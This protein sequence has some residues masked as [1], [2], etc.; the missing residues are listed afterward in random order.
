MLKILIKTCNRCLVKKSIL[1]L[2]KKAKV[3]KLV[4]I[5]YLNLNQTKRN[6]KLNKKM[7]KWR[8]LNKKTW[9]LLK[10]YKKNWKNKYYLLYKSIWLKK[11]SRK[12]YKQKA[13]IAN[14]SELLQLYA[15]QKQFENCK[16]ET[17][18]FTCE[19]LWILL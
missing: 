6:L 19:D 8:R 5:N 10:K 9:F 18:I 17:L 13:R 3:M 12:A 11:A 1:I 15:M 7:H 14:I 16:L 4:M 2:K